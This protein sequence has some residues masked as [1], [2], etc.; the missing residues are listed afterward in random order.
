MLK[1]KHSCIFSTPC[2]S[3]RFRL[4]KH[5]QSYTGRVNINAQFSAAKC[6]TSSIIL[7]FLKL[8]LSLWVHQQPFC[9]TGLNISRGKKYTMNQQLVLR[10]LIQMQ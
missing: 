1:G 4:I 3:R 5:L 10:A 2:Q 8:K 6:T 9:Y 7:H